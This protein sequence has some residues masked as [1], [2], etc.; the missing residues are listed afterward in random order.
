M[1]WHQGWDYNT[2][3]NGLNGAP[4]GFF[5]MSAAF[6]PRSL[7][8]TMRRFFFFVL[9]IAGLA[10]AAFQAIQCARLVSHVVA[11]PHQQLSPKTHSH[12]KDLP[13]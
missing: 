12:R 9:V 13:R 7:A 3:E 4:Y 5:S 2:D 6:V 8:R 10:G 11:T 1:S